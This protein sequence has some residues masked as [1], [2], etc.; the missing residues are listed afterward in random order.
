MNS[1]PVLKIKSHD[2]YTLLKRG[3]GFLRY[4]GSD[5][6]SKSSH[7]YLLSDSDDVMF[8][9]IPEK[10]QM[11]VTEKESFF[12]LLDELWR[13]SLSTS[14][15]TTKEK[16]K[17][18]NLGEAWLPFH[19]ISGLYEMNFATWEF[20]SPEGLFYLEISDLESKMG[21]SEKDDEVT[22]TD[23]V[24]EPSISPDRI[25][26]DEL[27]D[28]SEKESHKK[29]ETEKQVDSESKIEPNDEVD[30]LV[31]EKDDEKSI[32]SEVEEEEESEDKKIAKLNK[33]ED[34]SQ[35]KN[36]SENKLKKAT[37]ISKDKVQDVEQ[38]SPELDENSSG[39]TTG[40]EDESPTN[41]NV[42]DD[43]LEKT[44]NNSEDKE[45]NLSEHNPQLFPT[46]QYE[47]KNDE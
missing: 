45:K 11:A 39:D 24:Q 40:E 17:Y 21:L 22:D 28:G 23:Q 18:T 7:R 2:F 41:K 46:E 1:K 29:V 8:I 38:L 4:I 14:S 32:T 36:K 16:I 42:Q 20:L 35:E 33:E 30:N 26:E 34:S 27:K 47:K 10:Y 37:K 44:Q 25:K 31:E 6:K 12:F 5:E 9:E 19:Y 3:I 43:D 15:K 13:L